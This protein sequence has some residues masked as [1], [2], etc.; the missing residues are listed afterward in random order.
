MRG[1]IFMSEKNPVIQ[2]LLEKLFPEQTRRIQE[3]KCPF[4]GKKIDSENEFR[5]DISMNE[6]KISGL[7]QSCQDDFF[8][9]VESL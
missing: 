3:S 5:D 1:D 2:E 4:C 6:F 7:C 9:E 8:K